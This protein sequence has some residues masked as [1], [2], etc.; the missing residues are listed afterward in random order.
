MP[1]T[2]QF[3]IFVRILIFSFFNRIILIITEAA[4]QGKEYAIN[5]YTLQRRSDLCIPRNETALPRSQFP[6]SWICERF[7]YSQDPSAYLAAEK[8]E[9]D[10]GNIE[11]AHRLKELG[12]RPR[13][14]ISRNVCFEFLVQCL[15]SADDY[16]D[17]RV[18]G[19]TPRR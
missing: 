10:P 13:S 5:R 9:T 16:D 19:I 8:Q 3:M 11:I 14:F 2:R 12:M 18:K 17:A 7:I 4:L 15:C 1:L 6:H